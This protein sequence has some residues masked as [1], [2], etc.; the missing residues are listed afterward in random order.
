MNNDT[1]EMIEKLRRELRL[2]RIITIVSILLTLCMA[3]LVLY[4]QQTVKTAMEP[5]TEQMAD[6]DTD[7]LNEMIANLKTVSDELAQADI[8]WEKLSETVNSLDVEAL[9]EAIAGLD[10]EELSKAIENLNNAVEA[11]ENLGSSTSS[12]TDWLFGTD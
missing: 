10:T 11:L 1:T 5:L 7:T 9:N 12:L 6:L 4:F 3:G 8:D 2:T